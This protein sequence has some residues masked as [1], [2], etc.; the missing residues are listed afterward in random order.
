MFP[1]SPKKCVKKT[2]KAAR[3]RKLS[4]CLYLVWCI[5]LDAYAF[6]K[7]KYTLFVIEHHKQLFYQFHFGKW[8]IYNTRETFF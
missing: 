8:F 4:N 6:H 7:A 3:P 2:N 5:M 1:F